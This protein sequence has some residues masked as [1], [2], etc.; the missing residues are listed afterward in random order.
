[1]SIPLSS[2][3][4]MRRA[5]LPVASILG[6]CEAR[7]HRCPV[8]VRRVCAVQAL[9]GVEGDGAPRARLS[10]LRGGRYSLR[11]SLALR[12]EA[13]G[14]HSLAATEVHRGAGKGLVRVGAG[15]AFLVYTISVF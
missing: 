8:S 10:E 4:L 3:L 15:G 12:A 5:M 2:R 7:E 14:S 9:C 11:P 6:R 13:R 1:M